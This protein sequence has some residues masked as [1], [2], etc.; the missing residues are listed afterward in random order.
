MTQLPINIKIGNTTITISTGIESGDTLKKAIATS[1]DAEAE[2]LELKL[3]SVD[4]SDESAITELNAA[5]LTYAE[6]LL[7]GKRRKELLA[8]LNKNK[9]RFNSDLKT[10]LADLI[11]ENNKDV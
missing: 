8:F 1:P 7:R 10:W 4:E 6:K 9:H 2:A 5:V 11:R 3:M